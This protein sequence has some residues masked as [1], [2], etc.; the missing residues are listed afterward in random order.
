[1]SWSTYR[2]PWNDET[3]HYYV[4]LRNLQGVSGVYVIRDA[5]TH[6]PLY[7]GESHTD[8]LYDTITR[9]FREWRGWQAG[10]TYDREDVEIAVKVTSAAAAPDEQYATINRLQPRDN[11][12]G[13]YDPAD[14][15]D[16]PF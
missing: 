16:I 9:H 10:L 13:F 1:M 8:R 2:F 15:E 11:T 5:D 6:E 7:V 14:D 12:L 4:W 3:A